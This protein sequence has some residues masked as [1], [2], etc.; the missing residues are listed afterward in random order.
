MIK[1]WSALYGDAYMRQ[2]RDWKRVKMCGASD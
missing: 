2:A 1:G